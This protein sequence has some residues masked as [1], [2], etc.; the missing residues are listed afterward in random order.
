M[1]ELSKE[2]IYWV[3]CAGAY[4]ASIATSIVQNAGF[5][6]VLINESY[7]KALEVKGLVTTTGAID[8]NPVAPSDIKAKK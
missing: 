1:S 3:H 5:K 2:K 8:H 6:V 4:R 7:D